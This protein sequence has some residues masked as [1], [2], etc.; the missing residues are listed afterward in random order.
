[1]RAEVPPARRMNCRPRHFARRT[2]RSQFSA[3][4]A[5]ISVAYLLTQR[6]VHACRHDEAAAGVRRDGRQRPEDDAIARAM[7][8]RPPGAKHHDQRNIY[9]FSSFTT[10]A[11]ARTQFHGR[12]SRIYTAVHYGL[13][14]ADGRHDRNA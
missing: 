8:F 3:C 14:L 10:T 12:S 1:M 6:R 4:T 2:L 13:L 7:A 9:I 5:V 11:Y